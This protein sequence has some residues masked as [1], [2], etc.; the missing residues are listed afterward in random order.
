MPV[1]R[2]L[3][4]GFP[5]RCAPS[6]R[7]ILT[8]AYF[9]VSPFAIC[10]V[11][12]SLSSICASIARLFCSVRFFSGS[13]LCSL[14]GNP[15]PVI[16]PFSLAL[17]TRASDALPFVTHFRGVLGNFFIALRRL[18]YQ[19]VVILVRYNPHPVYLFGSFFKLRNHPF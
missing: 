2:P 1:F 7:H 5:L 15:T 6:A 8:S 18:D 4:P 11:F 9:P 10:P 13:V 17:L 3:F 14:Q 19:V 12:P 16:S